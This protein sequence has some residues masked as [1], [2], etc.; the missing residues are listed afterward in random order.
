MKR[1]REEI[2]DRVRTALGRREP[3]DA[4]AIVAEA[5]ALLA[6]PERLRPQ[7]PGGDA[8]ARFIAQATSERLTATVAEVASLADVPVAVSAY[9]ARA[10]LAP[11]IALPPDPRLLALDWS[12]IALR[13]TLAPDEPVAVTHAEWAIAETGSLVFTSGPATPTLFNFLPLHHVAIVLGGTVLGHMEDYWAL[14]RTAAA[15]PPRSINLI[16]GTSGTA[17]IEARNIRG[18]HGPRYMHIVLVG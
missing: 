8:R 1:A 3:L 16:T 4:A 17:D 18:A 14:V 11:S 9:L 10:G 5:A 12:G 2:L 7:I 6:R 13:E 15:P